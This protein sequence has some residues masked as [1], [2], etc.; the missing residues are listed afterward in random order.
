[1]SYPRK[2]NLRYLWKW[3]ECS[4]KDVYRR[5]RD[6]SGQHN[7]P[8]ENTIIEETVVQWNIKEKKNIVAV[9]H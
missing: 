6:I 1:M 4:V 2:Y 8:H 5:L 9:V 3:N 7:S